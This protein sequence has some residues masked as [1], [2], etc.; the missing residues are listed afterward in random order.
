[1]I[2]KINFLVIVVN[3]NKLVCHKEDGIIKMIKLLKLS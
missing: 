2:F 1:M 3:Y